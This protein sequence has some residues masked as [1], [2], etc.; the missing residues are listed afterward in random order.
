[1]KKL[2][3]TFI[4]TTASITLYG[5]TFILKGLQSANG[6]K[7][8]TV[9]EFIKRSKSAQDVANVQK[10][11][12]YTVKL[13]DTDNGLRIASTNTEE[14]PLEIGMFFEQDSQNDDRFVYKDDDGD[15]QY[16]IKLNTTFGYYRGFTLDFYKD[17][18]FC[19]FDKDMKK[20]GSFVFERK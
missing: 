1:M 17:E 9:E 19:W 15:I 10:L 14:G 4:L 18:A 6:N 20:A 3:L 8:F 13:E 7:H 11:K 16:V 2:F 5:Q 12:N